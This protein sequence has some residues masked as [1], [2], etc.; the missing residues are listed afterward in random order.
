MNFLKK[1]LETGDWYKQLFYMSP[2]C[3]SWLQDTAGGTPLTTGYMV[4]VCVSGPDIGYELPL[5]VRN[6]ALA[7]HPAKMRNLFRGVSRIILALARVPQPR[8]GAFRF[9]SR[10]G[11][12]ALDNRPITC[13]TFILESRMSDAAPPRLPQTTYNSV[14]RFFSSLATFHDEQFQADPNATLSENDCR[15]QMGTRAFLR[16]VAHQFINESRTHGPFALYMS[17]KN[18]ANM[19]VDRDWNVKA[20]YDLE[21]IISGP[22]DLPHLPS[23]LTW[24]AVDDIANDGVEHD[25]KYAEYDEARKAF[26]EVFREEEGVADCAAL[27]AALASAGS[28]STTLSDVMDETWTSKRIWFYKSIMS[29]DAMVQIAEAQIIPAFYGSTEL[30]Y[31]QVHRTWAPQADDIVKRKM[32][33]LATYRAQ[34]AAMFEKSCDAQPVGARH[35]LK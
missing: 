17:D 4:I 12:I 25:G 33:D 24:D 18:A 3:I 27:E 30:P 16:S 9:N 28:T 20:I 21:W 15:R 31:E 14:D 13:D 29:I 11:T 2:V 8:I 6:K 1:Y 22:V 10:D 26:M 7:L 32:D 23:W 35:A 19:I 5:V 34:V